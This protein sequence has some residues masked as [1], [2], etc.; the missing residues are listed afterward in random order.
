MITKIFIP[1]SNE[2]QEMTEDE[3][4]NLKETL[5]TQ[6]IISWIVTIN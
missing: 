4:I 5:A 3:A 6:N 2:Y 1:I